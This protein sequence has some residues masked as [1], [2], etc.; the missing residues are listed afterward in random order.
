LLHL[1]KTTL[2]YGDV[3]PKTWQMK[4]LCVFYIPALVITCAVLVLDT[5]TDWF[6]ARFDK[7]SI[8]EN[9][10]KTHAFRRLKKVDFNNDERVEYHE[11]LLGM[12]NYFHKTHQKIPDKFLFERLKSKFDELDVSKTGKINENDIEQ[13]QMKTRIISLGGFFEIMLLHFTELPLNKIPT[14]KVEFPPYVQEN[15]KMNKRLWLLNTILKNIFESI[16]GGRD[17]ITY[18][19]GKADNIFNERS[20]T[21]IQES[22]KQVVKYLKWCLLEGKIAHPDLNNA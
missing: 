18:S 3:T 20:D 15:E 10:I 7:D 19:P 17:T 4:L 13:Y 1:F 8:I 21:G 22:E 2:G 12:V 5:L 16:S 14:E 11:F 6:T 9:W